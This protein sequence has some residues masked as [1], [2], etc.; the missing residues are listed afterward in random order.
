VKTFAVSL[1]VTAELFVANAQDHLE[2]EPGVLSDKDE[3]YA[4]VREIFAPAYGSDIVLRIVIAASSIPEQVAG[5][6]KTADRYEAFVVV[7]ESAVW[8]TYFMVNAHPGG[9][10]LQQLKRRA[11]SEYRQIRIHFYSAPIPAE[12]VQRLVQIWH[13][14]LLDARK[15]TD[16]SIGLD[17]TTY[18]FDLSTLEGKSAEVWSPK[19]GTKTLALVNIGIALSKYAKG[20]LNEKELAQAL[21]KLK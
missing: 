17:G 3:Y 6:R 13:K 5:I 8:D 2:P 19:K 4:K 10:V 14:M 9:E 16:G 7:S 12:T 11:P 15:P 18:R 21:E 20:Q 1:V